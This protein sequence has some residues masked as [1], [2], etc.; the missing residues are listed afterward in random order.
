[1]NL[2][3]ILKIYGF[4]EM[5]DRQVEPDV[6]HQQN[7]ARTLDAKDIQTMTLEYRVN[8]NPVVTSS[9]CVPL[10]GGREYLITHQMATYARSDDLK[11]VENVIMTHTEVLRWYDIHLRKT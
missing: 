1:M 3:R 7:W 5:P 11:H 4:E 9:H 6:F 2:K 8:A 10:N